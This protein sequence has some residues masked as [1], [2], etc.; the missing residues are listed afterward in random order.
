VCLEGEK[1]RDN[2]EERVR[3]L[4][5]YTHYGMTIGGGGN[6]NQMVTWFHWSGQQSLWTLVGEVSEG[7]ERRG[8]K[9]GK[10]SGVHRV[11]RSTRVWGD[12]N[13]KSKREVMTKGTGKRTSGSLVTKKRKKQLE[14]RVKEPAMQLGVCKSDG[15]V[16]SRPVPEKDTS[17]A[18]FVER[19]R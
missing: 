19:A 7:V 5:P 18:T 11:K 16:H 2:G 8:G 14:G 17:N 4:S 1:E 13:V 10:N 6:L 9:K 3:V 12:S 15:R